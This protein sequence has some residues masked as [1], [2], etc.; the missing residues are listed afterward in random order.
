MCVICHDKWFRSLDVTAKAAVR[1]RWAAH[2]RDASSRRTKRVFRDDEPDWRCDACATDKSIKAYCV[3]TNKWVW[4]NPHTKMC[5]GCHAAFIAS[6]TPRELERLRARWA[7]DTARRKS[8]S[9][10]AWHRR[11]HS[12]TS[13]R[14]RAEKRC[15]EDAPRSSPKRARDAPRPSPKRARDAPRPMDEVTRAET[16]DSIYSVMGRFFVT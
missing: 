9:M 1:A 14:G 2:T 13:E 16:L 6:R 8:A 5:R 4:Y 10:R 15:V 3:K 11:P 7:K 12:T